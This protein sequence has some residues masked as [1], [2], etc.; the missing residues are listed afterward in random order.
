MSAGAIMAG[1]LFKP[2]AEVNKPPLNFLLN[3]LYN[4]LKKILVM[5]LEKL[6]EKAS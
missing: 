4:A 1:R 3:C 2:P 5:L 6:N